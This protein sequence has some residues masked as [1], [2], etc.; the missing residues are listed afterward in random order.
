MKKLLNPRGYLSWTQVDMWRRSRERYIQNY[1]LGEDKTLDNSGLQYGKTTSERLESGPGGQRG[2]DELL[3][4][5][6]S[7][8][9]RYELS[10]HE[11]RVPMNTKFGQVDLLGRLDTY[12]PYPL[13][14]RE[15][16]TGRVKWTQTKAQTHKQMH[17]YATLIFLESGR[18][19]MEAWLDWA[20][21]EEV[22]G[23]VGFTGNIHSFEVKLTLGSVLDYMALAGTVAREIDEE[24]KIQLKKLS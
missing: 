24:Y 6:A 10:E 9:P 12:N 4:A 8:L 5:V 15:Y 14:F 3:E 22:D 7:L 23:L 18:L 19:P 16:K 17:H 13:R 20:E 2:D 21:T 1:M 11:I